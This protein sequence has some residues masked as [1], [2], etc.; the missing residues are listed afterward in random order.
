[1]KRET[2][3]K[4]ITKH[5]YGSKITEIAKYLTNKNSYIIATI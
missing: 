5:Q 4:K 2:S 3:Y 1:M